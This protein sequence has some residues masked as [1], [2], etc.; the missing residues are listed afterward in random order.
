[1]E[2][3]GADRILAALPNRPNRPHQPNWV[4]K[5]ERHQ[6]QEPDKINKVPKGTFTQMSPSEIV[7]DIK[8]KSDS[9]E[10]AISRVQYYIN[11]SGDQLTEA[12]KHKMDQVKEGLYRSY[13]RPIP[14]DSFGS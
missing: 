8:T 5:A 6:A 10:Q 11:R 13:G 1:M 14:K 9:F 2:F 7:Q 4:R 3:N 12:D